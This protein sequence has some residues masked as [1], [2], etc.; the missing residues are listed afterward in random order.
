MP[1]CYL[2]VGD[3]IVTFES[4]LAEYANY[5]DDSYIFNYPASR[6]WHIVYNVPLASLASTYAKT[7]THHAGYVYITDDSGANPYDTSPSY[8]TAEL[9][10]M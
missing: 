3:I 4:P 10:L 8:L 2:S 1:E 6:F 9:N 7:Q 5:Q